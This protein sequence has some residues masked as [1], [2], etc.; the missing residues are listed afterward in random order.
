VG[1]LEDDWP[2]GAVVAMGP[3]QVRIV[4]AVRSTQEEL[5]SKRT[6]LQPGNGIAARLQTHGAGRGGRA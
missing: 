3:L 5:W 6:W 2:E 4:G 1:R